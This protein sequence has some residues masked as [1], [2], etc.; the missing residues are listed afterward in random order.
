MLC[1]RLMISSLRGICSR[2][3]LTSLVRPPPTYGHRCPLQSTR[4]SSPV[5]GRNSEISLH[6][7]NAPSIIIERN[8]TLQSN[9]R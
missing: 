1:R 3:M 6:Y 7:Q 5:A 8:A 9:H 4:L 2:F